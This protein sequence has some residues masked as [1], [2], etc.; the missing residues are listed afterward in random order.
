MTNLL[1]HRKGTWL[2]LTIVICFSL[3]DVALGQRRKSR[4]LK[5]DAQYRDGTV[6]LRIAGQF[7]G[8]E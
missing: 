5:Y 1:T 7:A 3:S 8:L 6:L 2:L 4:I